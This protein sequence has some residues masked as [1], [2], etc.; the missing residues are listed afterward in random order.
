MSQIVLRAVEAAKETQK[1][2]GAIL[3]RILR[4]LHIDQ[5]DNDLPE[6]TLPLKTVEDLRA[7]ENR[8]QTD[9]VFK[10]K[11]VSCACMNEV[12]NEWNLNLNFV[13]ANNKA[14]TLWHL[15]NKK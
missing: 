11:L 7:I 15:A 3:Q 4:H 10:R 1:V 12:Y 6:G 13:C 2:H 9:I 14:V 8:L 5:N